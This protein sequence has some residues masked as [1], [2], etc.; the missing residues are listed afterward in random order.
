LFLLGWEKEN[1]KQLMVAVMKAAE[2]VLQEE[3]E[4]QDEIDK[5]QAEGEEPQGPGQGPGQTPKKKKVANDYDDLLPP[6]IVTTPTPLP[7]ASETVT[8][9]DARKRKAVDAQLNYWL[10]RFPERDP[11]ITMLAFWK[12]HSDCMLRRIALRA[13]SFMISQCATERVNKIPKE[14]WRDG[15]MRLNAE[16]V[17]RDVFLHANMDRVSV[18]EYS[19]ADLV[20]E[21]E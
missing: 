13:A 5:T 9:E 2:K 8:S 10:Q 12:S 6:N 3:L 11:T 18:E 20:I 14:V 4:L 16:S 7:P 19:W 21:E 15:R 1:A 17:A